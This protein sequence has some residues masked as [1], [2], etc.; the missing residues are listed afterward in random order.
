MELLVW[1]IAVML[2]ASNDNWLYKGMQVGLLLYA[3]VRVLTVF[4]L[5]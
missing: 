3:V 2:A 1:C 4:D 5:L